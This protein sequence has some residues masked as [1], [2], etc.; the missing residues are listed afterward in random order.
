MKCPKCQTEINSNAKFCTKCGCNLASE[1]A[2]VMR[3]PAPSREPAC[4]K[5]G[6]PL[7][8]GARF[9]TKCGEAAAAAAPPET[10][11]KTVMLYKTDVQNGYIPQEKQVH[12]AP[13]ILDEIIPPENKSRKEKSRKEKNK[14]TSRSSD[15]KQEDKAGRGMIISAVFLLLLAL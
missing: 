9:C 2:K 8:P 5:C 6:A 10:E 15:K 13:P 14:K 7:K 3:P 4:A 11:K 1:M 12:E